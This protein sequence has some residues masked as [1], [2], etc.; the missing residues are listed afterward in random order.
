MTN[1]LKSATLWGGVGGGET[2][3]FAVLGHTDPRTVAWQLI[4][5]QRLI[6]RLGSCRHLL[7]TVVRHG[8]RASRPP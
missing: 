2:R 5:Q 1:S 3:Q 6:E 4:L 8:D 7:G